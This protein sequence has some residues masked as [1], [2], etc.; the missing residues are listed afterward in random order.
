[1][2]VD[3]DAVD[4]SA[5]IVD[6]G[7]KRDDPV[8]IG[9]EVVHR[10]AGL[11][12]KVGIDIHHQR[13]GRGAERVLRI[14]VAAKRQ[15]RTGIAGRLRIVGQERIERLGQPA[16]LED[17]PAIEADPGDIGQ[18]AGDRL[19][20]QA[21]DA[22][23]IALGR[24]VDHD[25]DVG[26]L[27]LERLFQGGLGVGPDRR[28]GIMDAD[29]GLRGRGGSGQREGGSGKQRFHRLVSCG[30]LAVGRRVSRSVMGK[31]HAF[32]PPVAMPCVTRRWASRK[33][34]ISGSVTTT[35]AAI[36]GPTSSPASASR[37]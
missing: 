34:R 3:P 18:G 14:L 29:F 32:S 8:V 25:V 24:A 17:A 15:Q 9:W 7:G 33:P 27:R 12:D 35:E 23:G 31:P 20:Q 5:K 36:S 2:P 6:G 22:L 19:A 30:L 13:R 21:L 28:N 16:R 4:G 26:M 1:V 10:I 37:K 11:L